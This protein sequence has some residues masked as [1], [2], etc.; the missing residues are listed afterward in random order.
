MH[1]NLKV[2]LLNLKNII[3]IFLEKSLSGYWTDPS[4][5]IS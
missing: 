2:M 1:L 4:K 3:Y 5:Y